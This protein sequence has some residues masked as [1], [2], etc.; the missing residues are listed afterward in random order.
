MTGVQTC[1]LPIS[2]LQEI[3]GNSYGALIRVWSVNTGGTGGRYHYEFVAVGCYQGVGAT[4][5]YGSG[6]VTAGSGTINQL[7]LSTSA[8]TFDYKSSVTHYV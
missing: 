6:Y 3:N 2:S 4:R 7:V 8:G 1:A 5:N